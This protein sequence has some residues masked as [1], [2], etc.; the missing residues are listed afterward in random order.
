M[1][2][3]PTVVGELGFYL[4][5]ER[6]ASVVVDEPSVVYRLTRASLTEMEESHPTAASAL[7]RVVVTLVADRTADLIRV[8]NVLEA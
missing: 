2:G 6:G 1:R 8:V 7:H 5:Y 3:G 4:G